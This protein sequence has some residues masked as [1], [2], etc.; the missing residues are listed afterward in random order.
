M[1]EKASFY[2]NKKSWE[3]FKSIV[4]RKQ[5]SLR[6]LSKELNNI[7]EDYSLFYLEEN[8]KNLIGNDIKSFS[9]E[10]IK[11]NRPKVVGIKSEDLIREMRDSN[12]DLS[13]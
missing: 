9:T 7:I 2:P 5:G 8:L 3:K 6:T 13:R 1:K 11:R 12:V 10:E 4:Y